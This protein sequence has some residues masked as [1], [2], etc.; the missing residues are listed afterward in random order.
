M[1]NQ[2]FCDFP[3]LQ[4]AFKEELIKENELKNYLKQF[5]N[6]ILAKGFFVRN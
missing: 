6:G 2:Q 5:L 1:N 4:N 3:S